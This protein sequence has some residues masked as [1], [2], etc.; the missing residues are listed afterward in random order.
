MLTSHSA[1]FD[2]SGC[3]SSGNF[4]VTGGY[5]ASVKKWDEFDVHWKA[6]LQ[7][8]GVKEF[9]MT[10]FVTHHGEF[11]DDKWKQNS[12]YSENF[13]RKLVN[14]ICGRALFSPTV[15]ISLNDWREVNKE[16]KLKE[17]GYT[18]LAIAGI[19]CMLRIHT[20]CEDHK[21]PLEH[22]EFFHED[23]DEDKGH[24]KKIVEEVFGFDLPLK[25]K[26]LTPLQACDLIVWEAANAERQLVQ[27]TMVGPDFEL[28]PSIKEILDRIECD[29]LEF[30]A[31]AIR[32]T[33]VSREIPKR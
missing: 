11:K 14:A 27:Q 6:I 26:S 2:T 23:G 30:N 1:Y 3:R 7:K 13:L 15:L 31:E 9:H 12:G 5:L 28:R 33:A 22:V 24:L 21:I 32:K 10:D 25:G 19:S 29:P 16:Y 20:W 18:P 8:A 17:T 4:L